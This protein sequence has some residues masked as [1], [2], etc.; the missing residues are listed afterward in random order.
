[1]SVDA[2]LVREIR[3]IELPAVFSFIETLPKAV[4]T[5]LAKPA[6]TLPCRASALR[7]HMNMATRLSV[8]LDDETLLLAAKR[9]E[10]PLPADAHAVLKFRDAD[11]VESKLVFDRPEWLKHPGISDREGLADRV[12]AS[13][14][15]GIAF[16]EESRDP[17]TGRVL[18]PGFR[19]AQIGALHAIAAHWT[20]SSAHAVVVM[21]TGTGKTE[22]MLACMV[23]QRQRHLLVLVPSD[24]L[25]IQ[26]YN[27]FAALGILRACGIVPEVAMSPVSAM[28]LG[29]PTAAASLSLCDECNVTVSTVAALQSLDNRPLREFLNKF[30]VVFFDEA[31]HVPARSWLRIAEA[32]Q[33]Q[34]VLQF[35]ATPFRLDGKRIPGRIIYNFPLRKAQEQGYFRRIRFIDVFEPD[36]DD[37]DRKIADRAV[38]QLRT[39]IAAGLN[40]VLLARAETVERASRLFTDIYAADYAD[41]SPVLIYSTVPGRKGILRQLRTGQHKIVVCVDMFGEGFDFPNLKI[42]A[43]HDVHQSLAVTLQFAGRFTR[44]ATGIGD[45]TLVANTADTRVS[46]A[47]EELYAE[48]SDW[49]L[50][51]PEMSAK[52]VQSQIEFS[53]F[54]EAMEQG[55]EDEEHLFALN[56]LKPKTSTVIYKTRSFKPTQFK[57]SIRSNTQ[58]VREWRSKSKDLLIFVTRSLV[59]IEWASIKEA[60]DEIWDLYVVAYDEERRLLFINS[61]NRATLHRELAQAVG[62][63]EAEIL[64]GEDMFR[65][66]NGIARLVFHNVGLYTRG[67][68]LS[69]R[70]YTGFDV[71]DAITPIVQSGATKSNFF[72]VGYENGVRVSIGVSHKGRL[73]SMS[74]GPVPDWLKWC[75][76]VASKVVDPRIHTNDFLKHTLIPKQVSALPNKRVLAVSWPADWYGA[77]FADVRLTRDGEAL[78]LHD[79]E[80]GLANLAGASIDIFV[81]DIGADRTRFKLRWGPTEGS[82][83]V[84]HLDGSMLKIA[85]KGNEV[86]LHDYFAEHPPIVYFLDGSELHGAKLLE[87]DTALTFTYDVDKIE[88]ADWSQV[89]IR[90]ESKWRNGVLRQ[91]SIQDA[92]ID[93]VVNAD[94]TFVFDDDDPGE[95]ADVVEIVEA[96]HEVL[97]RFYHCKYASGDA[98]GVRVADLEVVSAQA[99]RS[100][101]WTKDPEQ[102]IQHL[103]HRQSEQRRNGRPSR[104]EKG[105]L[106][107]LLRLKRKLARVRSRY[108]IVVVQPGLSKSKIDPA[109]ASILGAANGYILDTTGRPLRVVG[110][111]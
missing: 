31:H 89:D 71:G 43:M 36:R 96:E 65:A 73:W 10:Q 23:M 75:R 67:G 108:E 77:D 103:V 90:V 12:L 60:S 100:V 20:V 21:P 35:T 32:L 38:A 111:R 63:P 83:R 25:R 61:S 93:R 92:V 9:I 27:K 95:V 47:I 107:G 4:G 105:N 74:S 22:V 91:N 16:H 81:A 18:S 102:L 37:G 48:D 14:H 7:V 87:A 41:L 11:A 69:F 94:N 76:H 82:F 15:P 97:F 88:L 109:L 58:V 1:M 59:P 45:A 30:D 46:E 13:W 104:L 5:H 26:T 66:F 56:I 19:P 17:S 28:L 54:L 98:P 33:K 29:A 84:E 70:M 64:Q 79:V 6:E 39:D 99:V 51:I 24:A 85:V 57:P 86:L 53:D 80:I 72:A 2:Q 42:A 8:G 52:A 101:R 106:K 68:K 44:D 49:N 34:L 3:E 40:H 50:L 62:G 110:S 55:D 78:N